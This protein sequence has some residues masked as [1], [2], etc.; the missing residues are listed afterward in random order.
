MKLLDRE[1]ERFTQIVKEKGRLSK[2]AREQHTVCLAIEVIKDL[3][4]NLVMDGSGFFAKLHN[5]ELFE[6]VMQ[7]K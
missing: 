3:Q 5:K 2:E 1:A 4:T 7:F 6:R